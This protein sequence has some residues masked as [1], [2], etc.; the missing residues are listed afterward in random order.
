MNNLF[1]RTE[2]RFRKLLVGVLVVTL[3]AMLV[4]SVSAGCFHRCCRKPGKSPGYWKHNVK[5]YVEDQGSY[6]GTPKETDWKM[7]YYEGRIQDLPGLSEFSLEG[8]NEI[9]QDN[10]NK[11]MWLWL[12]NLFNWAAG[13]APY[14][15]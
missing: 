11:D 10:A 5:V 2:M 3:I 4:S 15:D 12:A 8:A 7:E 6:S 13:R 1:W 9:F 14:N